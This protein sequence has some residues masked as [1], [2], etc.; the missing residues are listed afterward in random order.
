[1]NKRPFI[2][3]ACTLINI[4]RIDEDEILYSNLQSCNIKIAEIVLDE[5]KKNIFKNGWSKEIN[6][7]ID[8]SLS[9]LMSRVMHNDEIVCNI[10][11]ENCDE[12]KE[13]TRHHKSD[14]E[15]YSLLLSLYLSRYEMT[16]IN[17]YTDDKPATD[18]FREYFMFQQLGLLGDSVDLILYMFCHSDKF[19]EF[20]LKRF[21]ENLKFEYNIKE[22]VF[23]Q[24]IEE[25]RSTVSNTKSNKN[26]LRILERVIYN[27]RNGE[28]TEMYKAIDELERSSQKGVRQ[29]IRKYRPDS[30]SSYIVK[31]IDRILSIMTKHK[32]FKIA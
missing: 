24:H 26:I 20:N 16:H 23:V 15:F 4:F 25:Y 7:R 11:A 14:G 9:Y 6:D 28:Y 31:K 1:M 5:V 21:L 29:I 30:S 3:D 8:R 32:V 12:I 17:L 10:K 19:S 2:L 22:R 27:Y 13:F 18:Q